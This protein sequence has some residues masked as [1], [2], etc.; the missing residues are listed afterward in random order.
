[1]WK[2]DIEKKQGE[3]GVTDFLNDN[4]LKIMTLVLSQEWLI[5]EK[6]GDITAHKNNNP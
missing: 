3:I 4:L 1:M 6:N 2:D 5:R